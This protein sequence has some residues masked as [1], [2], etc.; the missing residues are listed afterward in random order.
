MNYTKGQT[1]KLRDPYKGYHYG[2]LIAKEH[3]QWEVE[4]VGS[5]KIIWLY[6]DD[7]EIE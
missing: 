1:V 4:I 7:F 6:E 3:Y 5:G 2:V